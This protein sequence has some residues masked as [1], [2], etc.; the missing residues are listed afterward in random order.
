MTAYNLD[1]PVNILIEELT[2]LNNKFALRLKHGEQWQHLRPLANDIRK[3]IELIE[4][5]VNSFQK[6]S[7]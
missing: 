4:T 6:Q 5:K 1:I 7:T 2:K 3:I